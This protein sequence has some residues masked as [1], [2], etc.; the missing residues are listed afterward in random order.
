MAQQITDEQVDK[1]LE[2]PKNLNGTIIEKENKRYVRLTWGED[3][4][5]DIAGLE[6]LLYVAGIGKELALQASIDIKRNTYDYLTPNRFGKLYQFQVQARYEKQYSFEKS[7]VSDT[8]SVYVPSKELPTTSVWP[9]SLNGSKITLN[10]KYSN[11]IDDLAGFRLYEN[12]ELILS[13]KEL[14][15]DSRRWESSDLLPGKY[16]YQIEA[17]SKYA[18]KS[19]LSIPR[20]FNIK[21]DSSN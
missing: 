20:L 13:E 3:P 19:E 6:Y 14:T 16:E 2:K 4:H 7:P 21:A 12:G 18:I 10:W 1:L 15:A 11:L 9:I 5:E 17:V 8:L